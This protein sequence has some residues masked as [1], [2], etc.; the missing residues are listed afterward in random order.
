MHVCVSLCV[1]MY[2]R[3]HAHVSVCV[4]ACVVVVVII[5]LLLFKCPTQYSS[6]LCMFIADCLHLLLLSFSVSLILQF[7]VLVVGTAFVCLFF[8]FFS[9]LFVPPPP[10]FLLVVT[11][12]AHRLKKYHIDECIIIITITSISIITTMIKY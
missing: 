8:L 2:V 10:P 3:M 9:F 5:V 4:Y 11:G 1:C 6:N 7:L 12:Y